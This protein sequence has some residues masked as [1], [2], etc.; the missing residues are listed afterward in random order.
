MS[1]EHKSKESVRAYLLGNLDE[2][3][4][5]MLEE[6]YFAD[7]PFFEW[8]GTVEG[9]LIADYLNGRLS[10][11]EMAQFEGRYL[12]LPDLRKKVDALRVRPPEP[13]HPSRGI[14]WRFAMAAILAV[15]CVI[16]AWFL[17]RNSAAPRVA[18]K[19]SPP[20]VLAVHL[21]PGLEKG[22][23]ARQ[24]EFVPPPG[25]RVGLS[26]ELPG[27]QLSTEC[28]VLLVIMDAD[29]RRTNVWNSGLLK[30]EA[31]AVSQEARVDIDSATLPVGDYLGEVLA[32][33]GA[34]RET[35]SFR[36]S[37]PCPKASK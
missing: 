13:L 12:K 37:P 7:R 34:I 10:K 25:G 18:E 32:P 33:D 21:T 2:R 35:Y 23:G 29:G 15:G 19:T 5:S 31:G 4:T 3:E 20:I 30:T 9:E 17:L 6:R 28:R 26:L 27:V 11:A 22:D 36:V 8:M 14:R 24:V 16:S 1:S